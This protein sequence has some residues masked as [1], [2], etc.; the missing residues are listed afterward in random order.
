MAQCGGAAAR[1]QNAVF[2][3][4]DCHMLALAMQAKGLAGD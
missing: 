1:G 3:N 4:D 2:S